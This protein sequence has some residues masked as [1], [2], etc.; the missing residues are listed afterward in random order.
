[1]TQ[2]STEH[3][4]L[5]GITNRYRILVQKHHTEFSIEITELRWEKSMK[6][7]LR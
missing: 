1:V 7:H 3:V 2:Q 4:T 6:M 5:I